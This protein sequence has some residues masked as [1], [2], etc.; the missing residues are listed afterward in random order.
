M[1]MKLGRKHVTGKDQYVRHVQRKK[2]LLFVSFSVGRAGVE[3]SQGTTL[4][5]EDIRHL[6]LVH[7]NRSSELLF[8]LFDV[9]QRLVNIILFSFGGQNVTEQ[10]RELQ[11]RVLSNPHRGT[12][13]D[14]NPHCC[15]S[16]SMSGPKRPLLMRIY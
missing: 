9:I 2:H 16:R 3:R 11:D 6:F 1:I 7:F 15:H 5:T 13:N 10:R 12:S 8:L 4:A 14:A